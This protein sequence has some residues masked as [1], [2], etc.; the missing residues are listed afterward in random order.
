MLLTIDRH[1]DLIGLSLSETYLLSIKEHLN[2]EV[3]RQAVDDDEQ[4]I[5][6]YKTVHYGFH[7]A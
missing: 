4:L 1:V 5:S 2:H 7:V 3:E 6:C